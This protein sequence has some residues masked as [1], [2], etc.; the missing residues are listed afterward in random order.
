MH[1]HKAHRTVTVVCASAALAAAGA[2]AVAAPALAG[3]DVTHSAGTLV[4]YDPTTAG[5]QPVP[6]G[7]RAKV[8]SVATPQGRT[9]VTLTVTGMQPDE[10]YG[11]HAH[12]AGC[13]LDVKGAGHWQKVPLPADV[14]NSPAHANPQNEIWLDLTTDAEGNGSAKAVVDWQ[15]RPAEAPRSVIIHANHTDTGA[16]D[17]K[18]AGT[19]GDKLAC[20]PAF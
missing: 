6:V 2:L 1:Q 11:A 19:A 7:A 4:R 3:A 14:A 5:I 18:K 13:A 12:T 20:L 8:H 15:F 10:T 17:P 9:I 16:T